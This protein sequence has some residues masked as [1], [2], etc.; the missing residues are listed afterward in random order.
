MKK[1]SVKNDKFE[2]PALG[3]GCMRI[4]ELET[5]KAIAS[6]IDTAMEEGINFFDHA[7]IYGAG[8]CEELFGKVVSPSMRENMLIQTK[9]GIRKGICYDFSK[10]HILKS[11]EGSLKR[12]QTD[13]IDILLLHRPDPLFDFEEVAEAFS[14]L[15]KSG[16]VKYFGVSNH[17]VMQMELM[18]QCLNGKILFN[19]MQYSIVHSYMID[20]ALTVNTPLPN[21]IDREGGVLEYCRLHHITM[22]SWSPFYGTDRTKGVFIDNP[23]FEQLNIVLKR[24]AEKYETNVNAI[25]VAWIMRHPANIQTIVGTTKES[26]LKEVCEASDVVLT[27]EEWYELYLSAGKTFP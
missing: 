17:N 13:Y 21:A 23:E 8:L 20:A 2:I 26:R 10:E 22:Q 6:F 11:V 1:F 3:L 27:R 9:C 18:N 14:I 15:E 5:E 12:L 19:Q 25:A 24:L 4:S 16:K 7:D